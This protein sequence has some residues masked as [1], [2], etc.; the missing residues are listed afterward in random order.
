MKNWV[1]WSLLFSFLLIASKGT[2][3]AQNLQF[4]ELGD[5][6]VESGEVIR[7]CR[8][9]Y[10][11]FGRLNSDKS[12]AILFPTWASGT[13]AQ[14]Q[15][16][17]GSGKMVDDSKYFVFAIDALSNGVSSS[18]SNSKLQPRMRFPK[19]TIRDMVNTQHEL[20][21]RVLHLNHVKAVMGISMGGMQTF[22]WMV[23]Y[24]EF[25]D[26]A[27]PIVGS[28]KLT[29]Y[30]LLLWQAELHAIEADGNWKHG[31]YAAPPEAGMRTVADIHQLAL[32]TPAYR[33]KATAPKD[34]PKFL[35]SAEEE[36]M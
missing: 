29:A 30:D 2:V 14:L 3:V 36:T 32:E 12:N 26:K 21:T 7:A 19:V 27:I 13:T 15:S 10:R 23:A 6:K 1:R 11:T 9:G 35:A 5:F 8:I 34:F 16:N 33:A 22:Q 28:P 18:P 4:A 25:M 17:I 20:L 31:D 24:P